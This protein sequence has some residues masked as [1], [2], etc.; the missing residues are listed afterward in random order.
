MDV[1]MFRDGEDGKPSE[2]IHLLFSGE[3]VETVLDP[4][5]FQVIEL[6]WLVR[7]LLVQNRNE[8]GMQLRDLIGVGLVDESW[9]DK[10]PAELAKR[11][12]HVLE[13]P[14]G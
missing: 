14:D 6:E 8:D 10:L 9:L 3:S 4:E 7:S 11:L 1:V 12:K 13:T 2:A 5:N